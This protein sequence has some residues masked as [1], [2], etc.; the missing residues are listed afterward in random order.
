MDRVILIPSYQPDEKLLGLLKRIDL[1]EFDVFV[2]DDGSGSDYDDIFKE[3]KKYAKVIRYDVNHGKGYALKLG[4]KTIKEKY[5]K[6][7]IVTMDSDG[8]HTIEDAKNL[9]DYVID[10]PNT[11]VLGMRRRDKK[12]PL[13]SRIGN[14]ITKAVYSLVAGVNVYDT[15][16]GLRA[17]SNQLVDFMINI[18]GNR[19]EYEMN[20]LLM[21]ARNHIYIHEIPIQTIYIEDNKSSHFDT[22]KDSYRIYKEILKFSFASICSFCID[23]LLYFL[24]VTMTGYLVFSNILARIISSCFN[25]IMNKRFVFQVNGNRVTSALSYFLLAIFILV[26]N[27]FFLYLLVNKMY[28][29]KWLAKLIVEFVLF[30]VSWFVQKN[31]IFKN[32]K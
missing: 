17:F 7:V 32:R 5:S 23:Y 10:N 1:N 16:T 12:V 22:L 9:C 18:S 30:F 26:C 29:S 27:T 2:V 31:I 6:Y 3:C 24:F 20:V 4:I 13:R 11:L 28:I 19:F 21:C 14:G 15:Q 8:Q 25:Y